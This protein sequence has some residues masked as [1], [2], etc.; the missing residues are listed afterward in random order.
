MLTSEQEEIA[1]TLERMVPDRS[2]A[3]RA[4]EGGP[5]VDR[6]LWGKLAELG[7]LGLALPEELGGTGL[8]LGE[9]CVVLETLAA[10]VAPVPLIST[11]LAARI[12]G[13]GEG[14]AAA[15]LAEQL[16]SGE[17]IVG[18][19]LLAEGGDG[20]AMMLSDGAA[21]TGE[22]AEVVE[23]AT[24]D[25]LLIPAEGAWWAVEAN[26]P[27]VQRSE[28][29]SFDPTRSMARVELARAPAK[30]VSALDLERVLD[31]ARTL[32][33]AEALG[34]AQAA[35]DMARTHSLDRQQ[36]G[37][38]IG[39]FQAIKQKMADDLIATENARSAV[40]GAVRSAPDSWPDAAAAR[41]AKAEATAA[42]VK[43]VADA[44]QT[45]GAMGVTWEH[46][47][48]LLMRRAKYGQHVLGAPDQH[49]RILGDALMAD[50]VGG[51][52]GG[53]PQGD[54][55]DL[56][57]QPTEEDLAFIQ[58]FKDWL[59]EH[60]TPERLEEVRRGGLSA[61]RAW[62]SFMA[63]AGWVGLHWPV[64]YGGKGASF[65][66]QILYY[67]E[68]AKR[69][70][71]ALPGNR[72]L[73]LVGPTL[74]AHGTEEQKKLLEPTRR[75]DILWSGG[76]SERGSGSDLASLRT[77]AELD[78]DHFVVNGHKIW[79]SNAEVADWLYTLVRTGPLHPKHDGISVLLID[80]KTPGV[81]VRPIKRNS[82]DHA[83]NEVF[84]DEVKVPLANLVG[85]LNEGWRVNRTTMVGE[86]LTNFLGSQ[87]AQANTIRRITRALQERE[88]RL[89][90][91]A[92]LRKRLAEA[93][94]RTQIVKLHGLRNVARF[95]GG[96]NP[97]AEGSISKVVGQEHEQ[98]LFELMLDVQGVKGLYEGT[99]TRAYM[100]TRASTIG[101]GTSEIHRNRLA[102]RVL[103]LPR[104]LWAD[105]EQGASAA[106]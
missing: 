28:I 72:G 43:V 96:D 5:K 15:A 84:F 61:K 33:A 20:K 45:H 17:R 29:N 10:K 9:E 80:M 104:D 35:L 101:G 105:E 75:A 39:R 86:H 11:Y 2:A 14:D 62:Q 46:D 36:F 70:L 65:T 82:G 74:V 56:G 6:E 106:D 21:L 12:L 73:M 97:G 58:P 16:V 89:G 64:A 79:T 95:T 87:T 37:Q 68:I 67:A 7:L 1:R 13:A 81:E 98:R 71:G 32:L 4:L 27:G 92:D 24:P 91:D 100:S 52:K 60:L 57:F 25:V 22:L 50:A 30:K 99:W 49:L 102:E 78:G 103:G 40:W 8:G 51:R 38:P 85:P 55:Q 18:A 93:W 94:A 54:T 3:R 90:P 34:V 42:A 19:A 23:G 83:F 66:Q 26:G 44:V 47:L 63:Q 53:K 69:Q 76:F 31:A 88:A 59:D 41:L 48:H 77:K